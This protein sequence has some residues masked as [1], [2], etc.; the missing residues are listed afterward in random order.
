MIV[1]KSVA[2]IINAISA[3]IKISVK[4]IAT[5]WAKIM[6]GELSGVITLFNMSVSILSSVWIVKYA[7]LF[8]ASSKLFMKS[9][10]N[11]YCCCL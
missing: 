5:F 9:I 3:A 4:I 7:V 6:L 1:D 10:L 2:A 11:M 8:I